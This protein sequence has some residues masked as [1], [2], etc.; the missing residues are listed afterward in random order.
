MKKL[1]KLFA[2]SAVLLFCTLA[3]NFSALADPTNVLDS[4]V[5]TGE[6]FS[7]SSSDGTVFTQQ[8]YNGDANLIDCEATSDGTFCINIGKDENDNDVYEIVELSDFANPLFNCEDAGFEAKG[9]RPAICSAIAVEDERIQYVAG[10]LNKNGSAIV[11][12]TDG[13]CAN[14]PIVQDRPPIID[15]DKV[16]EG[17]LYVENRNTV[18]L[19]MDNSPAAPTVVTVANG[20]DVGL[21]KGK[22]KE[23]ILDVAQVADSNEAV[24]YAITTSFGRLISFTSTLGVV[25]NIKQVCLL[26]QNNCGASSNLSFDVT[27]NAERGGPIYALVSS[28]GSG[29]G[30]VFVYSNNLS[31]GFVPFD[32]N[33]PSI[34]T[35]ENGLFL[36]VFEG[37]NIDFTQCSGAGCDIGNTTTLVFDRAPGTATNGTAWDIRNIPHCAWI[38]GECVDP[39]EE[40][41]ESP[42]CNGKDPKTCMCDEGVLRVV[43]PL[44]EGVP[45]PT[46]AECIGAPPGLLDLNVTPLLPPNLVAEFSSFPADL[47]MP[48]DFQAQPEVGP[49]G[50]P[51]YHFD[52]LLFDAGDAQSSEMPELIVD[53]Q[54]ELPPSY[55]CPA[56]SIEKSLS[57]VKSSV[58]LRMREG[59]LT[60]GTCST[61]PGTGVRS[62]TLDEHM[63]SMITYDCS[64][65]TVSRGCC[66]LYPLNAQLA[67]RPPAQKTVDG[68]PVWYIDS[69]GNADPEPEED[70]SA[71]AKFVRSHFNDLEVFEWPACNDE[72][73]DPNGLDPLD[74]GTCDQLEAKRQN[75]EA[76]LVHALLNTA[77]GTNCSQSSR[78]YQSFVTQIKNY[79]ATA[80]AY[81]G[82]FP[83]CNDDDDNDG[84]LLTDANDPDCQGADLDPMDG[85]PDDISADRAGRVQALIAHASVL[86]YVVNEILEPTI[87]TVCTNGWVEDDPN[88]EWITN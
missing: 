59:P 10:V 21:A 60:G 88:L 29:N 52:A 46:I 71:A 35:R 84:D 77:D 13:V 83:A 78:N 23:E 8:F 58:V 4:L 31:G 17:L 65:P 27:Q 5:V 41:R 9:R 85:I 11:K 48:P 62:C 79:I 22:D 24:R 67:L 34:D 38:P 63:G 50:G 2:A 15:L 80:A 75:A 44:D 55:G 69:E 73:N 18:V 45:T 47:W 43:G 86:P 49:D 26:G 28:D 12:C 70:D 32:V 20:R 76:K 1:I 53:A 14:N 66:S 61:D 72:D 51:G 19:L 30:I 25:E 64:N 82:N 42:V 87:T 36:S 40:S 16:P 37:Q 7:V 39:L 68:V 3:F 56:D 54:N 81:E 6:D 74:Q 57:P 33:A